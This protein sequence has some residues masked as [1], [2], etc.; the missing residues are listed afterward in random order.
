MTNSQF[1]ATQAEGNVAAFI[2]A[3]HC[4]D[5]DYA[6][7][8][9]VKVE[10]L[11]I[12]QPDYGEQALEIAVNL[13]GI[14]G[15]GDLIVIDSVAAL[16]P[17][18]ELDGTME[19]S[20]MALQARMMGQAI[21]KITGI[22][23]KNNVTIIFI[24]QI[25]DKMGVTYGARTETPGGK[26]LKFYASQRIEVTSLGHLKATENKVESV[27]GNKTQYKIVKNKTFP[28]FRT[29]ETEIHFGRGVPRILDV[30]KLAEARGIVTKEGMSLVYQG[31]KL[32]NSLRQAYLFLLDEAET[33]E[34]IEKEVVESY[35]K[36]S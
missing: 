16:T 22:L 7:N 24:N 21:R 6:R 9:G 31:G 26:A 12:S 28:P 1:A 2:D 34:W 15:D 4:L 25:R 36:K 33:A 18:A 29:A 17:K 13:A 10:E 32:G 14:M 35:A 20:H 19:D 30:L 3:E 27:V 11:L 5:V 23:S 8:L